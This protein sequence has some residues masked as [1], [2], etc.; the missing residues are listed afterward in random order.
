MYPNGTSF[1][2]NEGRF[3]VVCLLSKLLNLEKRK[4]RRRKKEREDEEDKEEE[5]ERE[6]ESRKSEGREREEMR[7]EAERFRVPSRGPGEGEG[8]PRWWPRGVGGGGGGK[9]EEKDGNLERKEATSRRNFH[10]SFE[11]SGVE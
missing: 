9:T 10:R 7:E 11:I 6:D 3:Q 1:H 2:L 4:F 8:L 5:E